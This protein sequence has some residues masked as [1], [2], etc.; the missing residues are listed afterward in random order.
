MKQYKVLSQNDNWWTGK[1]KP[2]LL[3]KALNSHAQQGW[4]V[5]AATTS[6]IPGFFGHHDEMVIVMEREIESEAAEAARKRK[7]AEV[8]GR[9]FAAAPAAPR[10]F[11]PVAAPGESPIRKASAGEAE[12]APYKL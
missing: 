4:Q 6:S 7:V 10:I 2:D 5:I 12:A 11:A 8:A 9:S 1:F 3:E